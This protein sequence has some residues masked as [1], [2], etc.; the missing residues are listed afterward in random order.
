MKSISTI[1][2]FVSLIIFGHKSQAQI[3]QGTV[4]IGSGATQMTMT[5]TVNNNTSNVSFS[6][7]GPVSRWFG[8]GFGTS[9]MATGAYTIV[10]NVGSS[11][12]QEYNQVNHSV[13]NIQSTQNLS[14]VAAVTSG[15]S[16]TYTFTRAMNTGD[17]N[18]YIFTSNPVSIPFIWAYGTSLSLVEHASRDIS[19]ISL[20]S[21]CNIPVL[22]IP[23][24]AICSGD[25]ALIFGNYENQSAIYYDTLQSYLGCDSVIRQQ[26]SVGQPYL[27]YLGDTSMCIGDSIYLFDR[28]ISQSGT[29]YD[30]LQTMAGCDS[31]YYLS[32]N[33]MYIDTNV[34]VDNTGLYANAFSTSYQWYDCQNNQAIPGAN[35]MF[36]MPS[37]NGSYK[38]EISS[39]SCVKMSN[40]HQF[41]SVGINE[42]NPDLIKI[43]PNPVSANLFIEL[44]ATQDKLIVMIFSI[45]GRKIKEFSLQ[46][47]IN[48]V[49]LSDLQSGMYIYQIIANQL[50]IK[51]GRFIKE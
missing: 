43:M 34:Y 10:S 39:M 17:P 7:S 19:T 18:D 4:I 47:G 36:Y 38:V 49:E 6:I 27:Q 48:T 11:N 33:A 14:N 50:T 37:Q 24:I 16:K 45:D 21:I 22:T 28:W 26:L 1:I 30:S 5:I 42:I 40:C 13:P 41:T 12:P 20:A 31:I 32:V 9:S 15:S 8:F 3:N 25:S 46:S 29:Y 23:A 35:N 44:P 2:L 51:N